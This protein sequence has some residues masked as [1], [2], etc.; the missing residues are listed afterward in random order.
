MMG[1]K[2]QKRM[3]T[4]IFLS[5]LL[6]SSFSAY[7]EEEKRF[8]VLF[9]G[10]VSYATSCF[11][12]SP[13][14]SFSYYLRSNLTLSLDFGAAY[15]LP[16]LDF[17]QFGITVGEGEQEIRVSVRNHYRLF[18]FLSAEYHFATSPRL[19]PFVT[20]GVGWCWDHADLT[21]NTWSYPAP[22]E[23]SIAQERYRSSRFPLFLVGGGLR[24]YVRKNEVLR[25]TVRLLDPGGDFTTYQFIAGW[26]FCF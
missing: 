17:R 20:A 9:C 26:G 6:V 3:V 1:S 12:F 14:V 23:F 10:G 19:K 25:V 18:S 11:G 7:A 4:L 22:G 13:G 21:V 24:Y 5:S 2:S 15:H 8:E 16:D